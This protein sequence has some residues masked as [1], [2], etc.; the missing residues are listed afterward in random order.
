MKDIDMTG[1]LTFWISWM[2]ITAF[3]VAV[4]AYLFIAYFF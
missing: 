1:E 3:L 4:D 2:T